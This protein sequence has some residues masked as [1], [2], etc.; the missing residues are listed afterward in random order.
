[1]QVNNINNYNL[2]NNTSFAG[3]TSLQCR[4]L[5][6]KAPELSKNLIEAFKQNPE[7]MEFCK[8][9]DVDIVFYA[10]KKATSMVESTMHM[11]FDN[12]AVTGFK[13]FLNK[14]GGKRDSVVI[15]GF[16]N[17]GL[18][19]STENLVEAI[20][21]ESVK[22]GKGILTAHLQYAE[23][24]IAKALDK[25]KAKMALKAAKEVELAEKKAKDNI[26]KKALQD[27]IND[28]L[29]ASK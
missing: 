2:K 22:N 11:F 10:V 7:A 15:Y 14:L 29:N 24:N 26:D 4:G 8:K 19:G 6:K 13:K 20:L 12:P 5:Y 9:H 23:E 27:S 3:I 16:G 18:E 17:S 28:L 25:K 1:M 21:P